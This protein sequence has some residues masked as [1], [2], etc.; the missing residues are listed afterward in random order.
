MG[1]HRWVAVDVKTAADRDRPKLQASA[2]PALVYVSSTYQDLKD[3]RHA[4]RSALQR[5]G[6]DDIAMETYTAGEERPVDRC[7]D[8]VRSADIYVGVLAWRYGFVPAG[9]HTSI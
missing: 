6:L 8:D 5:M 4:V 2:R 7:L 1:D 9:G 3:C